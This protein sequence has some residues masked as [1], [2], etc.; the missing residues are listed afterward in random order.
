MGAVASAG[1][2]KAGALFD[3]LLDQVHVQ[4]A[5]VGIIICLDRQHW[6]LDGKQSVAYVPG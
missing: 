4:H 5:S 6:T 2:P 1:K 3:G